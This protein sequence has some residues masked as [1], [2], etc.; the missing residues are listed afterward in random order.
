MLPGRLLNRERESGLG[1]ATEVTVL[2]SR[3]VSLALIV[4]AALAGVCC[5]AQELTA[6]PSATAQAG[7]LVQRLSQGRY[8]EAV[9]RFDPQMSQALPADKLRSV[10]EGVIGQVGAF[11]QIVDRRA[12]AT[13]TGQAVVVACEFAKATLDIRVAVNGEG[14]VTGLWF[15]PHDAAADYRLPDYV[16]ADAF[17][18]TEVT[19]GEG[20][21]SLPGT[22]S[23]PKGD[24]P[25]PALVLVHGSGPQD[26]DETLGPNKPFRDLAGGLA[27]HGIAVLRYDKRTRVHGAKMANMRELTVKEETIDDALAAVALLRTTAGIDPARTYVLGHSLGGMLIPRIG[28]AE[29]GIAGLIAAAGNVRPLEDLVVEQVT[30]IASLKKEPLSAAEQAQLDAICAQAAKVKDPALGPD[31]PPEQ[32]PFGSLA[33]YW[34]DLRGYDP[35]ALAKTLKQPMLILQGGRDYQVT[36]ADFDLWKAALG[37]RAD[38]EFRFYDNLNHEFITGEGMA[39]PEE[40]MSTVGHVAQIVVEDIAAWIGR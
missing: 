13:A 24:G 34:L 23:T 31:T 5:Q 37:E 22:L 12:K 16:R 19:V 25:F 6:Q 15:A 32:L 33:P 38:V 36:K 10:W 21:W 14:K 7:S 39:T 29:P 1:T 3:R 30:Y 8:A 11:Q 18:E 35:A 20:E 26:R 27:S 17:T 4:L 28:Q 40:Y 2:V 9:A